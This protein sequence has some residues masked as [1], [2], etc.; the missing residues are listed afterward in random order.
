MLALFAGSALLLAMIGLYGV[1]A[2]HVV[3]RL[4]EIG[5]RVA[6][7]AS[8]GNV[9]QMVLRRGL[10]LVAAGIALGVPAA[11]GATRLLQ[12]QLF[13]VDPTDTGT[14]V[15]VSV[16]FMV[17]GMVACLIPAIRAMRVDPLTALQA[18]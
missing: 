7:G 11:A 10:L 9:V 13:G 18:E 14:F 17:V 16:C 3:Q 12:R 1:L 2:Y 8:S 15:G 5:V 6:L 4:H